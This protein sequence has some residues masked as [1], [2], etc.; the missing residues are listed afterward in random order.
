MSHEIRTPLNGVLGVTELLRRTHLDQEQTRLVEAIASAGH[1]LLDLLGDILDLAKIEEGQI[2][3]ERVD[4]NPG[5]LV[6]DVTTIYR[7]VAAGRGLSM[8]TEFGG[9]AQNWVSGDPTRLRQVLSNLLGNAIK[10][11]QRGEVRLH[12]EPLEPRLDDPRAWWRF[13]VKDTG[14]GIAPDAIGALFQRFSQA[15]ASTTRQFGGTGLGL[16]I[17]K[18]L[19][20]LM[21]GKI[22]VTSVIGEGSCF[23]FD[24][25]L[26]PPTA[27]PLVERSRHLPLIRTTARILV[28]EDNP[29][30][31]LVIKGLLGRFGA[32]VTMVDNGAI[33]VERMRDNSFHLIFM[34]CLMPIMDGF[35]ATRQIRAWEQT[36]SGTGPIPIIALTANALSGDRE[37][38]VE[39][40]MTGYVTKPT[41]AARLAEVL[42]QHLPA[43]LCLPDPSPLQSIQGISARRDNPPSDLSRPQPR[44]AA[45]AHL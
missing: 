17:C 24:L 23:S 18:H 34:D 36:Q 21:G 44:M 30:N 32:T 3:L 10:F 12:I 31:Q 35:E 43:E 25:P 33:A 11:T 39:A 20:E 9:I 6:S 45:I 4:F 7:E 5:Q 41:T 37:D 14:I 42:T 16:A 22:E 1:T 27:P 29:V 2:K 15:D 26:S 28:A 8:D 13:S 19:V 38:C 40:G